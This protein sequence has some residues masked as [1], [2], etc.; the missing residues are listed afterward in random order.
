VSWFNT[1]S[2]QGPGC[3]RGAPDINNHIGVVYTELRFTDKAIQHYERGIANYTKAHIS[4][5]K[6]ML[7]ATPSDAA[8]GIPLVIVCQ[9]LC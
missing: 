7:I 3:L 6:D 9:S 2:E 1:T 4:V 8:S 5:D